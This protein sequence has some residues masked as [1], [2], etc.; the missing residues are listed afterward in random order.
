M[1]IS[2]VKASTK[3]TVESIDP[4]CK[5]AKSAFEQINSWKDKHKNDKEYKINYYDR[6][7]FIAQKRKVIVDFGDAKRYI[8]VSCNKREWE[9][10]TTWKNRP[11]D[12]SI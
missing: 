7:M 11:V 10:I 5:T 6:V 9:D 1:K 2:L 12:L 8:T 4:K 3:R